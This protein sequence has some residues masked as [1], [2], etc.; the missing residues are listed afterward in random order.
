MEAWTTLTWLAAVEGDGH[1][2]R[3]GGAVDRALDRARTR[4]AKLPAAVA[5][6]EVAAAAVRERVPQGR[7]C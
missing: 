5:K 1:E 2:R 3:R 7:R 6:A 4:K